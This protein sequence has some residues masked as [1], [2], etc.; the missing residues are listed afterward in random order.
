METKQNIQFQIRNVEILEIELKNP[1]VKLPKEITF[2]FN[3]TIEHKIDPHQKFIMVRVGIKVSNVEDETNILG[4]I[5][6][7]C[8]YAIKN[9][10]EV[11][12]KTSPTE[13]YIPDDIIDLLNSISISTA[14]GVMTALF[15]GTSLHRAV[16][17]VVNP[18]DLNKNRLSK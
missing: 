12:K 15:K 17:P 16:L 5:L 2:N 8:V 13:Y 1:E 3:L 11:I 9:F 14:R 6:V 18:K 7:G 4:H 10:D